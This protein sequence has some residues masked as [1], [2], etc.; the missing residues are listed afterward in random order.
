MSHCKTHSMQIVFAWDTMNIEWVWACSSVR[1]GRLDNARRLAWAGR[2]F[3][4]SYHGR[5]RAGKHEDTARLVGGDEECLVLRD[6]FNGG[7]EVREVI[8]VSGSEAQVDDVDP[9]SQTP[10]DCAKNDGG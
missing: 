5:E 3:G 2:I 8:A 10:V 1:R 9:L 4:D 7:G 6:L